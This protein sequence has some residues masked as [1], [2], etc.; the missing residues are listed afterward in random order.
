MPRSATG[1]SAID[2]VRGARARRTRG[3]T[4]MEMLVV[5]A[6]IGIVAGGV[7]LSL[8]LTGRDPQLKTAGRRLLVLMRYAHD[9]A[10]LQTRDYGIVFTRHGY[11]F[12]VYSVRHAVWR[13][14]SEDD[15]LRRRT[16]PGGLR[17][18]LTVDARPIVLREHPDPHPGALVPQ[19]M[20]FSSGDLSSFRITIDRE[21]A[22]RSITLD[23]NQNGRI[24]EKPMVVRGT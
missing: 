24:V 1:I 10:Q 13:P 23:Q 22:G 19:V 20:L 9:Q 6:I 11:Q 7:L 17:F 4:L 14:V 16:L 3:F 5:V 21:S 12:V 15:A 18:R 8:N 2:S